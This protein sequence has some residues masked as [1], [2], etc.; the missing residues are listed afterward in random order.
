MTAVFPQNIEAK[1]LA[2]MRDAN[3]WES[4]YSTWTAYQA[5]KMQS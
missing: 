2:E 1:M 5:D 4:P 3:Q